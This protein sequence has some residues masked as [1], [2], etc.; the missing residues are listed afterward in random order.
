MVPNW[1][2]A[3]DVRAG[4]LVALRLGRAGLRRTWMAAVSRKRA[5]DPW[6]KAFVKLV[7]SEPRLL[8]T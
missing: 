1:V 4:R 3:P 2:I 6:F 7:A 8:A 5:A